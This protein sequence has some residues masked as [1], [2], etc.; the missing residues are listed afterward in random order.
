M[1]FFEQRY[2]LTTPQLN[3]WNLRKFYP[4][5]SIVNVSGMIRFTLI[6]N[7]KALNRAINLLIE[8]NDAFRLNF[9][10]ENGQPYQ[11]VNPYIS[12][13][14]PEYDMRGKTLAEVDEFFMALGQEPFMP[15]HTNMYRFAIINLDDDQ[16][17]VFLCANHLI[18][19]AWSISL[20][21]KE[22]V[23]YYQQELSGGAEANPL[24]S[25]LDA[26]TSEQT[27]F[28]SAK[29]EKDKIYWDAVFT[30]KPQLCRIKDVKETRNSA[31][32]RYTCELDSSFCNDIE[33]YCKQENVTPAVL[34][35]AAIFAYLHCI[36]E[37]A[38][39]V[40]IGV[41]LLNRG[42][43]IEKKTIGMFIS[44]AL[45]SVKIN[46]SINMTELCHEIKRKH[47]ETFR[48]QKY[49]VSHILQSIRT[50]DTDISNL[51]DV[52]VSYQNARID[53]LG[54]DVNAIWYPNGH[55]EV[56]LCVHIEDLGNTGGYKLHF[57][58]Q[59][60]VLS[61]SETEMLCERFLHILRQTVDNR[62]IKV[63]DVQ[64][65]TPTEYQRVIHDF[66]D[67]AISYPSE[68]C[69]HQ[70]FEEQ[71]AKNPDTIAAI[72]EDVEYTYRQINE[73]ANALAHVLR[74]KGVNR[75]DIVAIIAKRSYK[76]LV[77]QLAILKAG[78]AYLPIDP[79]YP[80]DRIAYML[81]DAKCKIALTLDA[82]VDGVD[83]ID[84][85]DEKVFSGKTTNVDN[86]N[87]PQDLCYVIYTS[88]STGMPK[89]TMLSHQNVGNYVDDNNNNV[90]HAIIKPNMTTM[91]SITTIGFDI[92][93][94]ESLLP[95]CNGKTV[96]FAN[97]KQANEQS[98]LNELILEKGA[99]ILQ[100]TPSKMQLLM[101]D[102]KQTGYLKRLRTIILGGEALD[103]QIVEK[104]TS[105]TNADIYNIY[106]P[107]ETTVWS[108]NAHIGTIV[109]VPIHQLIEKQAM[110]VSNAIALIACDKTLS[111]A[112]LNNYVNKIANSL[113]E[114]NIKTDDVIALVLPRRSYYITAMLGILK[115]GGAYLPLDVSYP[116][117]RIGFLLNDS[118]AKMVITTQEYAEKCSFDGEI[119]LIDDLLACKNIDNPNVS[120]GKDDLFCAL[121]TSG[122]TGTPK[123]AGLTHGNI[124]NFMYTAKWMFDGVETSLST[125]TVSFDVFMQETLLAL[126]CGIKV[127]FFSEQEITDQAKFE[128]RIEQYNNCYLFQTPTRLESHIKNSRTKG[129]LKHIRTFIVGGEV[130][131][132]SLFELIN[133]YNDNNN[134]FNVYGPSENTPYSVISPLSKWKVYNGFGPI[135]ATVGASY[136]RLPRWNAFNVYGPAESYIAT[137]LSSETSDIT[138][139]RPIANTQIYILDKNLNPLPIG[140]AGELCISGDGVGRGYL[141]RPELTAEKFIPNPFIE[142]KRMYRTGDLARW[143][144][145][146]QLEYIGR[147]DNQV[148]I[149]GLR[150][151]LGE[152][153]AAI[154]KIMGIMQVAV[155]D[156]KDE[157]ERQYICAYYIS[158]REVDEKAMRSELA[159]TLPRYMVPHF[160]TRMDAFPTTPSGKTDRKAFPSPDFTQSQSDVEY[161]APA[162]EKEKV[163]VRILEDV[164][165]VSPIGMGDDFFD[166]GGDSLK[167]IEFVAKAYNDGIYFA[168][169][170]VFDYPTPNALID[171]M[172]NGDKMTV[173]YTAADFD[174]FDTIL[175]R[176]QID[177]SFVPIKAD[178]GN[179]FLTGSTGFLGAH[180]LDAY[181]R[182]GTGTAYCLVRGNN[183]DDAKKRF[184]NMMTFY[185]GDAYANNERI[186]VVCGDITDSISVNANIHTVIHS[187]ATVKHYGSY[188]FFH[189][190]NVTG[191]K[192]VL[193]FAREKNANVIH[194]STIGVSG[195]A[196]EDDY[197]G[198]VQVNDGH[199]YEYNLFVEQPLDNVYIRSK[200]EAEVEVLQAMLDGQRANIVRVGNLTNR[201]SD[202]KFQP[203]YKENAYLTR[204]K[205]ALEFGVLPD[206]LLPLESE[207]SMV[208]STAKAVIKIA[209]YFNDTF[210]VFHANNKNKI[211][212]DRLIE[213]VKTLS[214][215]LEAVSAKAFIEALKSVAAKSDMGYVYEAFI[216]DLNESGRLNYENA[217]IIENAFTAWYLNRFGFEWPEVDADYLTKYIQYFRKIGYLEV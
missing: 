206:Y 132:P 142:G 63:Y 59:I 53:G 17:G 99:D 119:L 208:D 184:S 25:F 106:G 38:T 23:R 207:L 156:R 67:T 82:Q 167:A 73:M 212:I 47:Y 163:L 60:S 181:L 88:G 111:F 127:V 138:I 134:T 139:G 22:I 70:L 3:I 178:M 77:A 151:E 211:R 200:F 171:C 205:A 179:L 146:G 150:I 36:N 57:D 6:Y 126:A 136:A 131:P 44:T 215:N 129:F 194:I 183:D 153:E 213:I 16:C 72:F 89:G 34:F 135:E 154:A 162:T 217:T 37:F 19:D 35:E 54:I 112:E 61:S 107:T 169:Q 46:E 21:S 191:T 128:A 100:T 216:N 197:S 78:G 203:N 4:D 140:A 56:P 86:I 42:N 196:F 180:I 133:Q 102:E 174:K 66:N 173:Q 93:V 123:V 104:L 187:A 30:E 164:L 198:Y 182:N 188:K 80:K 157:N 15:E 105:Y 81:G 141:N 122:S 192:N 193:A 214:I 95:L 68:K 172:A 117:E 71:A 109:D 201:L 45:L 26:I 51:R 9:F 1:S 113:I 79:N 2:P 124:N 12:E 137:Q 87:F 175:K 55:S 40:T 10:E 97:D 120:I 96:L 108:A 101:M 166:L 62:A 177:E 130:F 11:V 210:C 160:F 202:A 28:S 52:M 69:V 159:K 20:L 118:N 29:Y 31:T 110:R 145:D 85:A 39:P 143:R 195:E 170:N 168:L 92:F 64:I 189:D 41:P 18:C 185:F 90:V 27:Y 116:K 7:Y 65:V 147:M 43:A 50:K 165:G 48:H 14:I 75:D 98:A 74:G 33:S 149:R 158:D 115:S 204:V 176:N 103:T 91:V 49:P 199:F 83:A 94:T 114:K 125:T 155:V 161:V 58:H 84:M 186:V 152:I 24:P 76:I 190:M 13:R 32:A 209:E 5:T 121:H 144:E 8:N 148:K